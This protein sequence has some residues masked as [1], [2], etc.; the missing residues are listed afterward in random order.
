MPPATTNVKRQFIQQYSGKHSGGSGEFLDLFD[1]SP[2]PGS[3][4]PG[5]PAIDGSSDYLDADGVVVS[6]RNVSGGVVA[7]GRSPGK[8][9]ASSTIQ[10][11]QPAQPANQDEQFQLNSGDYL[12]APFTLIRDSREQYP[13]SFQQIIGL[14]TKKQEKDRRRPVVVPVDV[15]ALQT[16]DYTLAGSDSV[17]IPWKFKVAVERKSIS[18]AWGTFSGDRDRWERELV[19]LAALDFALIIVE[20]SLESCVK[21]QPKSSSGSTAAA[22]KFTGMSFHRSILAWQ[23]D[24]PKIQWLFCDS[25]GLAE[26]S[27]FRYLE[28][29]WVADRDAAKKRGKGE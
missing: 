11:Q 15:E 23:Q 22:R 13:W 14:K 27:C 4:A 18:D 20:A 1:D 12:T 19:R 3:P 17:N 9:P 6:D 5:L 25:R 16:G 7:S 29:I 28:R 10:S 8:S 21:Y 2:A 24:Y 26:E